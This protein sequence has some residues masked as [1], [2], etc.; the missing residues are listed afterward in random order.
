[1]KTLPLS[2]IWQPV[3]TTTMLLGMNPFVVRRHKIVLSRVR[4][5]HTV[6]F[7][8]LCLYLTFYYFDNVADTTYSKYGSP[9]VMKFVL[10][11][12][13]VALTAKLL[14]VLLLSRNTFQTVTKAM[15]NVAGI[16]RHL[17]KLGLQQHLEA[18]N[19]ET[20][21]TAVT[22]LVVINGVFNT[23]GSVYNT[24]CKT[25]GHVVYFLMSWYPLVVVST[26][27]ITQFV[28]SMVMKVRFEAINGVLSDKISESKKCQSYPEVEDFGESLDSL[29]GLHKGL[30]GTC[31]EVYANF[32]LMSLVWIVTMFV[33]LTCDAYAFLHVL[34]Y[35]ETMK[36]L[37]IVFGLVKNCTNYIIHLYWLAKKCNDLCQEVGSWCCCL[38]YFW[39]VGAGY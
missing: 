6:T 24:Y 15:K 35:E 21:Q 11:F 30:V 25:T 31:E 37:K 19:H 13:L 36:Y 27:L 4:L 23:L 10:S 32:S 12:R 9:S 18:R 29:V 22:L 7:A 28:V 20:R 26:H 2:K 33:I 17:T 1:M 38:F 34:M 14:L 16:D 5:L 39:V 3:D 8:S